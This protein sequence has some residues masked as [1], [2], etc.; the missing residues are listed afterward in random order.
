MA[1]LSVHSGEGFGI[2]VIAAAVA[3]ILVY[4]LLQMVARMFGITI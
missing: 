3:L 2:V 1:E 4:P